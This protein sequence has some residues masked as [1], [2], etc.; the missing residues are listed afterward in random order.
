MMSTNYGILYDGAPWTGYQMDGTKTVQEN[1]VAF[2]NELRESNEFV[3][4]DLEISY[5]NI[6]YQYTSMENGRYECQ[7]ILM[8]GQESDYAYDSYES[9]TFHYPVPSMSQLL[10]G[11][12]SVQMDSYVGESILQVIERF[13]LE[14]QLPSDSLDPNTT[15]VPG[16][17]ETSVVYLYPVSYCPFFNGGVNL[18]LTGVNPP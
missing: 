10:G 18:T 5:A 13:C 15:A 11:S 6:S 14:H 9:Q 3:A 7:L 2:V 1:L 16:L 8:G 17:G 4:G 12:T